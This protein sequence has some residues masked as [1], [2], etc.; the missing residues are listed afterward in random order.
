MAN[1][2][3]AP[4]FTVELVQV[5]EFCCACNDTPTF[6]LA[7]VSVVFVVTGP[8]QLLSTQTASMLM[9]AV[10]PVTFRFVS[11]TALVRV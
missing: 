2:C 5:N 10:V 1:V 9:G 8:E 3:E 4:A 7:N 11:E 6:I